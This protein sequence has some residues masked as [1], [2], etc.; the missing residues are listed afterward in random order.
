MQTFFPLPDIK[1]SM[2]CLDRK[3]LGNQIYNEGMIVFK[4][5]WAHHPA[6]KMWDGYKPALALYLMIG[7]DVL[8]ERG[9]YYDYYR[10]ALE[11]YL[12]GPVEMPP[13][14]GDEAF[15]A[16]HRSN[17]LRKDPIWYGQFGWT[18]PSDL[19]YVWP[20]TRDRNGVLL[21]SRV[22]QFYSCD[23]IGDPTATSR[24]SNQSDRPKED[25]M[26]QDTANTTA[27]EGAATES[28]AAAET[29]KRAAA[30]NFLPIVRGRLPLLFVHAVRFDKVLNA[31]SNKDL[32]S[33][34]AT[35]IGKIFDIK[36]NRNFAYVTE[37]YKP[38]A[39]DVSAAEAWITQVGAENAKGLTANGD[40]DL[41]QKTVDAYKAAGLAT[42]ADAAAFAAAR[43]AARSKAEATTAEGGA[44][45]E[46]AATKPAKAGK[47]KK[48]ETAGAGADPLS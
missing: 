48:V 41:M 1:Q 45:A 23:R 42:A 46:G 29:R 28:A 21:A 34:F 30:A 22:V 40:K 13:W 39:E 47:A 7:L 8:A 16:S 36:K 17:L 4:G 3:R 15:H 5:K 14:Y 25:T 18:E 9:L 44:P 33:K 19:P 24:T 37:S 31:M 32:A 26:N 12:Q 27:G 20:N 38:S 43:D 6:T 10:P 11:P 2:R 35:S